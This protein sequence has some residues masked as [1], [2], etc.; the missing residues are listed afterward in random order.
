[1]LTVIVADNADLAHHA[2]SR[3]SDDKFAVLGSRHPGKDS[4]LACGDEC[5]GSDLG[6]G[7]E[8]RR[9]SCVLMMES[10]LN[11]EAR[12]EYDTTRF[13]KFGSNK[14]MPLRS[15]SNA[16]MAVTKAEAK[17]LILARFKRLL[18]EQFDDYLRQYQ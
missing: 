5:E 4:V 7:G 6:A 2:G 9:G 17:K 15:Y 16:G 10:Q 12:Y 11:L 18:A 8:S 1:M 14:C 13:L 3:D